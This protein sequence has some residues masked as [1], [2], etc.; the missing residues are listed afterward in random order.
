VELFFFMV[1]NSR[2]SVAVK[3][4]KHCVTYCIVLFLLD[5]NT[6][7]PDKKSI[8]MYVMCLFQSLPHSEM[9][10]SHLDISIHS[11]SSP[12]MSSGAEVKSVCYVNCY[13]ALR[14]FF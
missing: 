8:M 14:D 10:M 6:S 11:D 5:V 12:I 2:A 7:V 9:D 4:F 3:I 1:V 13:D